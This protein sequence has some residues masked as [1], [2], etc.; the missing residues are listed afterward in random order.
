M[1]LTI[2]DLSSA[3]EL[4]HAAMA[5]V[6]GGSQ[7]NADVGNIL[8]GQQVW[9]PVM[10]ASGPGSAQNVFVDVDASQSAT[11]DTRQNN[12]DKFSL[13]LGFLREARGLI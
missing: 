12:G 13:A 8:Q 1:N 2:K 10:A 11:Q 7:G 6:R 3:T 4:D 9:V 5:A